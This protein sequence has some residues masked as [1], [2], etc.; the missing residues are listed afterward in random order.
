MSDPTF[1]N[2]AYNEDR[3]VAGDHPIRTRTVTVASSAALTRGA[4]LGIITASGKFLL[5]ASGASDGSQTPVAILARDADASGGDVT[6]ASVYI[7]GDFNEA[8]LSFGTGHDADSVREALRER[9][10]FIRAA[11][12]R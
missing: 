3:L 10:I 12:S 2:T 6:E 11:E 5:S 1:T 8:A 9:S 7:A 4:V